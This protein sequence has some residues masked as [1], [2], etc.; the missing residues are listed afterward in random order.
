MFYTL[1]SVFLVCTILTTL[2]TSLLVSLSMVLLDVT[3]IGLSSSLGVK[4]S[5][6]SFICVI[7]SVGL[8]VDYLLHMAHAVLEHDVETGVR[9]T[10]ISVFKG[11]GT[12]MLGVCVLSQTS[13]AGFRTFFTMLSATVGLGA[14]YSM[15]W[16]PVVGGVGEGVKGW[17][18][19]R[20]NERVGSG[21]RKDKR[22]GEEGR[23]GFEVTKLLRKGVREGG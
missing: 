2:R 17:W 3:L 9:T 12:T 22:E 14:G 13:S 16:I 18:K 10:G 1:I 4:L 19:G 20:G 5:F 11:A 23:R 21:G 7:M 15:I 6:V 8:S